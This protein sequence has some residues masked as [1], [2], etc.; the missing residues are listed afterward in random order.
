MLTVACGAAAEPVLP[1]VRPTHTL[2]QQASLTPTRTPTATPT[3]TQ[4]PVAVTGGPS[5]TPV[6][7]ELPTRPRYTQTPTTEAILPGALQIEYF[8]SSATSL[9]PGDSLTLFWSVKGVDTAIIYRLDAGGK[10]E[11]LWNVRRAGS[12]E[13][14]TRPSDRGIVQFLLYAGDDSTHIEQSLVVPFTCSE[15]WFFEPQPEGCPS[16]PPIPSAEV[17][18]TFERGSMIWVQ[19]QARIYVLFND[20]QKPAWAYFP[21]EF[22]E[23]QP[24]SDPAFAPPQ[25]LF[26]PI[27]GFGLVWRT[28]PGIRDRLGW[29][30]STEMPSD[31]M[32]QGD[33]TVEGG[34]MYIRATDG[35]I[36]QLS[37]RG[38]NWKLIT[39]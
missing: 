28:R 20:G 8:T 9:A 5:P 10:R 12:L 3:R 18:Q 36:F 37:D 25:G 14:E 38:A 29:A 4:V 23:G 31:G 21:D 13:V 22:S 15:T 24:E 35:A 33:A 6:I 11:Q 27:R 1:T 19:S 7:G 30:T 32:L 26:Q 17:Q 39:P 34:V 2:T 16:S